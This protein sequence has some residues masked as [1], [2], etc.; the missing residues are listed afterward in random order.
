MTDSIDII[1][2]GESMI[3]LSTNE[4]LTYAQILHKYYGGDTLCAAV[5]AARLGSKVGYI[6]RV[7]NDFFKDFLLDSWQAENIDINYVRLVDGYN[8]LYFISRQQSGEKQFAYYRKKSAA[9]TL[10]VDDIPEDYIERA[11]IIYSTGITQSISNSAKEAVGKAFNVAKEKGCMVA[12]DP[13]YRPQLW[14]ISEAKEA[15]EEIIDYVDIIFLNTSHDAEK[16]IGISSP[17][18][19]IKYFWDR[20]INTVVTK[21]GKDGSTIGYNG[22]MNH[23]PSCVT[24]VVDTTSAGDAYNGA[25]LHGITVGYTPFEAAKLACID[26]G[27]QVQGLGA[28]KSIPYK[29][30]VYAEFKRGDM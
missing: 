2:I 4:S 11:S 5:A 6:T 15:L 18:K 3:E 14:S 30:Q 27:M 26:S 22:E 16:L 19:I 24:S 7:G 25:F 10:S 28:I 8:G 17:D 23:V 9:S 21:M 13:N 12:Y 1:S 20:G 29:D